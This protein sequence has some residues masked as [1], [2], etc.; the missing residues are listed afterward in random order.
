MWYVLQTKTGMEETIIDSCRKHL[1][2]KVLHNIFQLRY[3]R[4]KKYQGEWRMDSEKLYPGYIFIE[5]LEPKELNQSLRRFEGIAWGL[6]DEREILSLY[7]Q[8]ES[9]LKSICGQDY[10]VKMSRGV[11]RDGQTII[12]EGPLKDYGERIRKIDRHKRLALVEAPLGHKI[13]EVKLGL[14][15]TEK[16]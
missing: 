7:E 9:F 14:E 16:N 8:E 3:E 4:M 15:I 1:S 5:S 11:I 10:T 12:S 6:G 13:R 2:G